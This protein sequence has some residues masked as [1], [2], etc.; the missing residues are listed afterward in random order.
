M[1]QKR[2]NPKERKIGKKQPEK[3]PLINPRYK[4]T[5]WTAVIIIVLLIFFIV[6]NTRSTPDQGQLPPGYNPKNLQ[7]KLHSEVPAAVDVIDSNK[8][9]N[10]QE[11]K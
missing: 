11:K 2:N 7:E 5:F 10:R 6:N 4:N 8:T 9:K 1:A 3:K